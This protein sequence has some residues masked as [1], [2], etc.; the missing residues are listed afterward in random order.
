MNKF[1]YFAG[2]AYIALCGAIV[3]REATINRA[4]VAAVYTAPTPPVRPAA[5]TSGEQWFAAIKQYCNPVEVEVQ[6]RNPDEVAVKG[7]PA[8]SMVAL[9]DVEKDVKKK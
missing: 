3:V 4:P 5:T 9:V 2:F 8:D 6:A 7:I 1:L